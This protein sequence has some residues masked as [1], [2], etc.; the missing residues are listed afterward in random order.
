MRR[1]CL[2]IREHSRS[3]LIHRLAKIGLLAAQKQAKKG[4]S[5]S[6]KL[7]PIISVV[8]IASLLDNSML[9][10]GFMTVTQGLNLPWMLLSGT[11]I[12]P[13]RAAEV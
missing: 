5:H 4:L 6:I 8:C 9:D 10:M 1:F 7:E 13:Q 2:A 11:A 12:Q 3:F